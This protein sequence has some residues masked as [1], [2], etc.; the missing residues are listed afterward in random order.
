MATIKED[1]VSYEVAKLLK[2]KGFDEEC[3]AYW[4]SRIDDLP[5]EYEII[6]FTEEPIH[7]PYDNMHSIRKRCLAP[8]HQMAMRWLRDVHKLSIEP[9]YMFPVIWEIDLKYIDKK[10]D[11]SEFEDIRDKSYNSYEEAT[12]AG[13]KYCLENLI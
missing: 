7:Q 8:T 2:E 12:E 10:T 6:R 1:Y 3:R 4:D 13:I 5:K 9:F 11:L